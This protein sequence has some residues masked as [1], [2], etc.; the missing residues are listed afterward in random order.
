MRLVFTPALD[1]MQEMDALQKQLA[2]DPHNA[3]LTEKIAHCTAVID[4]MDAYNMDTQIKK[5]LNGMG[6]P[7]DT[8]TKLA[9]VLSGGEQTRLRLA[10]L[11]LERPD[12]LILDEPTNHLDLETM[13]WLENYLKAYRGAVLVVS[14]DRYFLDA[15][16]TR[17]WELR[18]KSI[19]TYRGNY[20]AY[21][22]CLLYTSRGAAV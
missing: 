10:R 16:C 15:V 2:A 9:G 3:E 1:A 12:L 14:H 19:K 5:V 6:F 20:S 17:I 22:P 4:A 7:A 11:L 18:G 13:E 8:W 21:L